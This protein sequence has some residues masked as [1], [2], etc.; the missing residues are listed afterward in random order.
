MTWSVYEII[1]LAIHLLLQKEFLFL[2]STSGS[3]YH[4]NLQHVFVE[5][6]TYNWHSCPM[7]SEGQ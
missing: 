7:D 4:V 3:K 6:S 5:A 2:Q 1:P